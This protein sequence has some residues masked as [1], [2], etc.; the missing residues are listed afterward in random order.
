MP[1]INFEAVEKYVREKSQQKNFPDLKNYAKENHVP[2]ITDEVAKLLET[3]I[4]YQK[5]SKIL[6][7]GTAIAYSAL[8]M[9]KAFSGIEKIVTLEK[10]EEMA[11][12]AKNNIQ[13]YQSTA[14]IQILVGDALE[15]LKKI[16]EKFDFIFIDAQK[17]AYQKYFEEAMRLSEPG[18]IIV[19][20]NVLFKGMVADDAL[21]DKKHKTI[22][23][24]L[25]KFIDFVMESEE[26]NSSLIPSG[27]GILLIMRD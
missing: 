1:N 4:K 8:V 18:S 26:F 24:N 7:I 12:I 3:L 5:P 9:E 6:E 2:I 16:D 23:K 20:D 27:D 19:C 11:K 15:V 17:S 22:V 13:K 10:N 25:R 21:M 14:K